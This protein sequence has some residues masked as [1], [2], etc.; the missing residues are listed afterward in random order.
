MRN[1]KGSRLG[2]LQFVEKLTFLFQWWQNFMLTFERLP[3][4]EGAVAVR[5]LR[6]G[7][8]NRIAIGNLPFG[9]AK[10][11]P[12][13]VTPRCGAP[14]PPPRRRLSL[15]Q[16]LFWKNHIR[17]FSTACKEYCL[18]LLKFFKTKSEWRD[19]KASAH[20][21]SLIWLIS[22]L[23]LKCLKIPKM[24]WQISNMVL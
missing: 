22:H 12:S 5:R 15:C 8:P 23:K 9:K 13:S 18:V 6:V 11:H 16:M 4:G 14:P 21:I 17:T 10:R 20:Q 19:L 7:I 3:R 24:G 1:D 2:S